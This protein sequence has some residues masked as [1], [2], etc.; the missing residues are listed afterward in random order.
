MSL[1]N[2]RSRF[3]TSLHASTVREEDGKQRGGTRGYVGSATVCSIRRRPSRSGTIH[4]LQRIRIPASA[5][6]A[7]VRRMI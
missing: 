3:G 6:V 2:Y 5:H 4:D 7:V 1:P